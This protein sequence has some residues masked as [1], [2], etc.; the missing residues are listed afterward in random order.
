MKKIYFT[1]L[2]LAC[3]QMDM[4]AQYSSVIIDG[5]NVKGNLNNGGIFFNDP[6]QGNSGYEYPIG[7][8]KHLIFANSFWFQAEDS[9]GNQK[10]SA[11]RYN[12][13]QDIFPGALT[14]DGTATVGPGNHYTKEIYQVTKSEIDNHIANYSNT[15]N[16]IPSSILDWP[17]HGDVSI[18]QD[19]YLAPFIDVN[20]DGIYTPSDG[21]YPKI[22]GDY[23][24]YMILNDKLEIHGSG[25][26][27]MGLECHFMFYQYNS[28]DFRNNTTFLNLK[29]INRSTQDYPE[30]KV[31]CFLDSD[32]GNSTDDF[33]GCDT[34]LNTMY[35]YNYSNND[36]VYGTN[37]PSV[38]VVNLNQSM[39]V[40]GCFKFDSPFMMEPNVL[41]DY[42]NNLNGLWRDGSPYTVGGNGSGGNVTTKYLFSGNPNN[43]GEW[44]EIEAGQ[45]PGERKMFMVTE[46]GPLMF[47]EE[48]C[49]DYA[50]IIGD[51]GDHLQ[52]V[53][54][55]LDVAADAQSFFNTQQDFICENY[56]ETLEVSPFENVEPNIYPIPSNGQFTIEYP[57]KY[58]VEIHSLDGRK[59]FQN[60]KMYETQTVSTTLESGSYILSVIQGNNRYTRPII[61]K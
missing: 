5:N 56:E 12:L 7:S 52:N 28:T 30:F 57:G 29:V 3:F 6:A 58:S 18:G 24:T 45:A 35:G 39:D 59:V 19:F 23:A 51:G 34:T 61:I 36:A 41:S 37:P 55:L 42:F 54:N 9:F 21:D 50:F 27:P 8:G 40:F 25:G 44:S 47:Q 43:P 1:I 26:E 32:I 48:I 15:G 10:L 31:G 4:Q 60:S 2:A 14:S 11:Q 22:R 49:L 20:N 16:I 13:G 53:N 17:A 33:T 46:Q 38:G